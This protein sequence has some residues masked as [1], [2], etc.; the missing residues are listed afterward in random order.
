MLS[1]EKIDNIDLSVSKTENTHTHTTLCLVICCQYKNEQVKI[2]MY[3]LI[4]WNFSPK[5]DDFT[6]RETTYTRLLFQLFLYLKHILRV[7][8][9]AEW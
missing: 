4:S 9:W 7:S 1:Y 8:L 5:K 2:S 3:Q 6:I